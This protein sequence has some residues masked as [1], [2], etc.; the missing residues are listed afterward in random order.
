MF[1]CCVFGAEIVRGSSVF[2]VAK[3]AGDG[4]WFLGDEG[5]TAGA[6]YWFLGDEGQTVGGLENCFFRGVLKGLS[7]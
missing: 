1:V 7:R 6:G 4:F 3:I 5:E 2:L